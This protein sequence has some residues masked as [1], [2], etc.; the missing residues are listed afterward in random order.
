MRGTN[1]NDG[2]VFMADNDDDHKHAKPKKMA[3]P[4]LYTHLP[5]GLKLGVVGL[6]LN[7]SRL[8]F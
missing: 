2:L 8:C 6:V 5:A 4:I 3:W 7:Q 1:A